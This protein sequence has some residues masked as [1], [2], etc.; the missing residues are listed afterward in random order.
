MLPKSGVYYVPDEKLLAFL[1]ILR[2][3]IKAFEAEQ[4]YHQIK[5]I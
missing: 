3:K 5:K 4:D 1:T 2:E